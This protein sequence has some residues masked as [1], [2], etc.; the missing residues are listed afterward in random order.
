MIRLRVRDGCNVFPI[1]SGGKVGIN[2]GS[3]LRRFY[4]TFPA[5]IKGKTLEQF[6]TPNLAS[7]KSC[8]SIPR[9]G[10]GLLLPGHDPG[11]GGQAGWQFKRKHFGLSFGLK[12]SLRFHFD[13]MT[14]LNFFLG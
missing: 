3:G 4:A 13:S 7:G 11:K 12:N 1:I 9:G 14:C 10:R 5:D 8:A 2:R 6:R